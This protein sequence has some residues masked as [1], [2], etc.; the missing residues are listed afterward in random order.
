MDGS[1]EQRDGAIALLLSS[2]ITSSQIVVG[3]WLGLMG[4]W[5]LLLVAGFAYIPISLFWFSSPPAGPILV[6]F[7]ALVLLTGLGTAIGMM[8]SSLTGS[9]LL[10]AALSW[11]LLMFLWILSFTAELEGKLS[12]IGKSLGLT[13]SHRW[14]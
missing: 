6:G 10:S 9:P 14:S 1:E 13:E 4:F 2:P 3:K 7:L 11:G 5:L 12:A 8:A